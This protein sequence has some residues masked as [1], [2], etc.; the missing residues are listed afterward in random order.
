MPIDFRCTKC[1]RL[2]RTG[3]D[4]VGK[5]AKCPECGTIV[6][7]PVSP[8]GGEASGSPGAPP[9]GPAPDSQSP[10]GAAADSPFGAGGAGSENP[11]EAP[12][13]EATPGYPFGGPSIQP[14]YVPNYL[15]QAILCT[16]FCCLPFGI[17]AIVFAA[18]VNGHL[19]AGNFAAA[20]DASRAARTWCWVS[21]WLGLAPA[22]IWFVM[23]MFMG[24]AGSL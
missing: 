16:L 22:L 5:Q 14:G 3:D 17:V 18:Q 19:A 20:A 21:F 9:P 6:D 23:V 4:A 12:H 24:I 11:Y 8:A 10:F 13:A 7:V 15:V 1:N 2:L